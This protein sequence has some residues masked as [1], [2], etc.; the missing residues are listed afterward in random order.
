MQLL[1]LALSAFAGERPTQIHISDNPEAWYEGTS[2]VPGREIGIFVQFASAEHDPFYYSA[3]CSVTTPEQELVTVRTPPTLIE[4]GVDVVRS[5]LFLVE[6]PDA[7]VEVSCAPDYNPT[8]AIATEV[9]SV[10]AQRSQALAGPAKAVARTPFVPPV[11]SEEPASEFSGSEGPD[12]DA[13][14]EEAPDGDIPTAEADHTCVEA[15]T[16]AGWGA[17]TFGFCENV[18]PSCAVK[19]LE[20]GWPPSALSR[21][22]SE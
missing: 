22:V 7:T 21:C 19:F 11:S 6:W 14:A 3:D 12:V 8:W 17:S 9:P 13:P 2:P 5:P 4:S 18:E 16:R 15:L 20:A 10:W 1:L